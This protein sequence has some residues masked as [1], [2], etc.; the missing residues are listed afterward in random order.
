MSGS[1]WSVESIRLSVFCPNVPTGTEADW[2]TLT[3]QEEAEI[4]QN[5][6]GGK[7]FVGSVGL[8]RVTLG[9]GPGRVDVMMS[10]GPASPPDEVTVPT[11]AAWPE[12]ID[13]FDSLATSYLTKFANPITR[14]AFGSILLSF[15]EDE[16]G[17]NTILQKFISSAK[18][19]PASEDFLYRVN[20]PAVSR[21]NGAPL[22]RIT[23]F[24]SI[25]MQSGA[26]RLDG[27]REASVVLE[28][29]LFAARLEMD[30]STSATNTTPFPTNTL[31]PIWKELVALARENVEVGEKL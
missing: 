25:K 21:V 22:N 7:L 16:P 24:G 4:R 26:F 29:Q 2:K 28:E 3:G 20:L 12:A 17:V 23:T 15:A 18:I 6:P 14:I 11:F 27:G 19:Q 13:Q 31:V 1:N 9:F 5:V 8:G 30:H 10:K